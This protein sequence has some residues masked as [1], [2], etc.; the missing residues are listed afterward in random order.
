MVEMMKKT[1]PLDRNN[2]LTCALIMNFLCYSWI[3]LAELARLLC[4]IFL[5]LSIKPSKQKLTSTRIFFFVAFMIWSCASL[6]SPT[7][8]L[9][10]VFYTIY[11]V[12]IMAYVIMINNQ[13]NKLEIFVCLKN[14][15]RTIMILSIISIIIF[16]DISKDNIFG[17]TIAGL[18]DQLTGIIST[19]NYFYMLLCFY[20]VS[21]IIT[22]DVQTKKIEI[23]DLCAILLL[24]ILITK[25]PLV[26]RIS[27]AT[28]I[29]FLCYYYKLVAILFIAII[30]SILLYAD[31][32]F[33][34]LFKITDLVK[35]GILGN[36][37]ELWSNSISESLNNNLIFFGAGIGNEINFLSD[38]MV[39]SNYKG[40]HAHS[41]IFSSLIELGLFKAFIYLFFIMVIVIYNL[42]YDK[43]NWKILFPIL[44]TSIP[45]IIFDTTIQKPTNI[46]FLPFF[47]LLAV[48]GYKK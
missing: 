3:P 27:L 23:I 5:T 18:G 9:M 25:N 16:P 47:L 39:Y 42:Y 12:I 14:S 20:I 6:W 34:N 11:S 30:G 29:L 46:L 41:T 10:S 1:I 24:I 37:G 17:G 22:K 4:L 19:S 36:R 40:L 26:N 44:L 31:I 2:F 43:D 33:E 15:L 48:P 28:L 21:I 45:F 38:S 32:D 7:N 8:T 13:Y 35:F